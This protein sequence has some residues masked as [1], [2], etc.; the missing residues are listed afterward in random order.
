MRLEALVQDAPEDLYS[1][2]F[3]LVRVYG[4]DKKTLQHILRAVQ[5]EEE[6]KMMSQFAQ[7]IE[8][9]VRQKALTE[10]I[11]QG[12]QEGRQEGLMEGEA[13]GEA[14]LLLNLLSRRFQPLPDG[15]SERIHG[16]NPNTIEIWA[17]RVLDA[18]S[19]GEVFRD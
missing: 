15:V 19:L 1:I 5:P 3:Y 12:R 11:Q 14:K 7:D 13:R 9:T 16:A 18:K 17:D 2:A 8:R 6:E 10:G 4:Y